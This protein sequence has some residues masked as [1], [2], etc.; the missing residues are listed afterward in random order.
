MRL[1]HATLQNFRCAVFA[2]SCL[3]GVV[4]SLAAQGISSPFDKRGEKPRRLYVLHSGIHTIVANPSVNISA[5]R[6]EKGL[7]DRGVAPQDIVAMTNP[8]PKATWKSMFPKEAIEMFLD[9]LT[10]TSKITTDAY[11]RMHA[12]LR[13]RKATS[14]DEIIWIGHSAGGQLGM[15][16]AHL[17]HSLDRY[18]DFAKEV[19]PYRITMVVTLGTPVGA[20]LLPESV[21]LRNYY[22][23][24]DDVVRMAT[25]TKWLTSLAFGFKGELQPCSSVLCKSWKARVFSD[26]RHNAWTKEERIIDRIVS[27]L[28]PEYSPPWHSALCADNGMALAQVLCRA[29]DRE[30]HI[31][32][33]DPPRI[34]RK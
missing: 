31:S 27:E 29:L 17:A 9:S 5:E 23:H 19:S 14:E 15:T 30:L 3:A 32:Y 21:Q 12:A 13:D 25:K 26:V 1:H 10:P 16:V 4:P 8:F 22:S 18:P 24:G 34:K 20:N 2:L 33:E 11:R 28:G 6:L 7:R